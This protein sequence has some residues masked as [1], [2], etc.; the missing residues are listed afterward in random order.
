MPKEHLQPEG[1]IES[2]RFGFTQVVTSPP[3][4]QVF[5]SG[6]TAWNEKMEVVGG[7]D[8]GAQTEAAL[9]NLRIALVAAGAKPADVTSLR[10][11]IVDYKPEDMAGIGR[12]LAAFFDG[13][14]P[15]AQTLIG[16][17]S[18]AMPAFRVEIEA[19]AVVE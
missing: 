1:L 14:P 3:G 17:Q 19:T 10:I 18:L 12:P 8:L 5:V 16:V 9:A 4:R 6:Q 2:Q 7:D 13:G 11:Y 15:P